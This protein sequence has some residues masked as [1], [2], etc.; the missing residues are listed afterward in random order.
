MAAAVLELG[1]GAKG[2]SAGRRG[3]PRGRC[4]AYIG[5]GDGPR[6]AGHA[7]RREA[8][9][10]VAYGLEPESSS[11]W[12]TRLTGGARLAVRDGGGAPDWAKTR[13]LGRWRGFGPC[14]KE[15]KEGRGEENLGR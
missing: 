5:A 6:H 4:G 3:V 11:R 12:R 15:R 14:G 8:R 10:G 13:E 2:S 9:A 1:F 7:R